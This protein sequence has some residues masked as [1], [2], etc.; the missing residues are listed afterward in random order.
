MT[1]PACGRILH[2][3]THDGNTVSHC[4]KCKGIW[5]RAADIH[6]HLESLSVDLDPET[7]PF[8]AEKY[9]G[10]AFRDSERICPDC[11]TPLRQKDFSY[12][13]GILIL[14]CGNC[15][16]TW[17]NR[18]QDAIIARHMAESAAL[19]KQF[20][21]D[22]AP[23]SGVD[24]PDISAA[25]MGVMA[26]SMV[27]PTIYDDAPRRIVPYLTITFL[28][29]NCVA[30]AL[31]ISN[32][33]R[34]PTFFLLIPANLQEPILYGSLITHM[35]IHAGFFHLF[36]NMLYLWVFG[37][38]VEEEFGHRTFLMFYILSGLG[39]AGF[40]ILLNPD[41]TVPMVGASGAI[42]GIMGAYLVFH[43]AEEIRVYFRTSVLTL[44][45]WQFLGGWI[46]LQALQFALSYG[47]DG[48]GVA[49]DAHLAGFAT[50]V[51]VALAYRGIRPR[52]SRPTASTP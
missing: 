38:N 40:H 17:L 41:S 28:V 42:A 31:E 43:P 5:L 3:E 48:A 32:E 50:G 49:W 15:R 4:K 44:R 23:F 30:F 52:N 36:G 33:F 13:S 11:G 19:S 25:E 39:G 37:D 47:A 29:I 34:I 6:S 2:E 7:V 18:G 14:F 24:A 12:N 51:V 16:G 45:A 35:F 21:P 26:A 27:M 22:D 20:G 8:T 1:C 9:K 46:A 10:Q